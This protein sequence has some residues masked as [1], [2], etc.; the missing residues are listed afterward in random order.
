VLRLERLDR[1]ADRLTARHWHVSDL[2]WET[3]PV[4]PVPPDADARARR[5]FVE[6]GKRA[7][8]VQLAAEHVAVAAS[9]RLLQHCEVG[10]VPGAVTRA[11]A[12][13]MNDEASHVAVMLEL[14]SRAASAY[15]DVAVDVEPS[16]LFAA[17]VDAMPAL[18]PSAIAIAMGAYEAMIA[19]RSYAEEAAYRYPSVLGH[20]ADRAAHDDALHA[21]VLRIVSHVL[22]D[23]L[24]ATAD[25]AE[26]FAVQTRRLVIDPLLTFWPR[27]AE[28]ERF[29]LQ[30]DPR[31]QAALDRRLAA[32][33][34]LIRRLFAALGLSAPELEGVP[35]GSR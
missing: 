5:A 24:R 14:R 35:A 17:F 22:L 15:P 2:P 20:M 19:I 28:H 11:L 27:L 33:A 13:V 25:S 30:G 18:H 10:A 29:L 6:F 21:K 1:L 8:D 32:D 7:I 26:Q 3:L 12:A 31:F 23:E 16:P 9:H 34:A 4:L